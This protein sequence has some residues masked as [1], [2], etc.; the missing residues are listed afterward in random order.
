MKTPYSTS[1]SIIQWCHKWC[2]VEKKESSGY[3]RQEASIDSLQGAGKKIEYAN[4]KDHKA[5]KHNLERG[6]CSG[7]NSALYTLQ[8]ESEGMM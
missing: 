6:E 3:K 7:Q 8:K 4:R 2:Q 5:T 1:S